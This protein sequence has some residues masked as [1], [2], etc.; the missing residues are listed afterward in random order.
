MAKLPVSSL[1]SDQRRQGSDRV[2]GQCR[3]GYRPRPTENSACRRGPAAVG[4]GGSLGRGAREQ[5]GESDAGEADRRRK[6]RGKASSHGEAWDTR[7]NV[8][9]DKSGIDLKG[10]LRLKELGWRS[11]TGRIW[12]EG[13]TEAGFRPQ[14]Q[15][16]SDDLEGERMAIQM[17]IE[18]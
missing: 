5:T 14:L 18:W 4:R 15:R 10:S 2:S 13:S 12:K 17:W 1:S 6:V 11:Q 9:I 8:R 3:A 16:S 7:T